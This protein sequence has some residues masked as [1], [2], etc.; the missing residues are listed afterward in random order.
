MLF[1][2]RQLPSHPLVS[3]VTPVLNRVD[4][5]ND[6]LASV[7]AQTYRDIEHIVVDGGSNDGTLDVIRSFEARHDFRWISEPDNGMYDAINKGLSLATGDILA[8]VNSDDLYFP[9]AVEAAVEALRGGEDLV[10]SDVVILE[11]RGGKATGVTLQFYPSFDL[12]HYVHHD[13][14]PQVTC[15]WQRAVMDS[16]GVF[17]PQLRYC[18]DSE[19]W[20]RALA[21]GYRIEH[22][23]EISATVIDHEESFSRRDAEPLARELAMVRA[24]FSPLV[25]RA[26]NGRRR[27]VADTIRWRWRQYALQRQTRRSRPDRWPEF[28]GFLQRAGL[29]IEGSRLL[30]LLAPF[31]LT[32]SRSGWFSAPE[33]ERRLLE[34]L[35]ALAGAPPSSEPR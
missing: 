30:T 6:S 25:G 8:Y 23:D 9:W 17:D 20:A 11:K 7:A 27:K 29:E 24:R 26:T 28:I 16:I 31:R 15:F 32:S 18:G 13:V 19:Y 3:I 2:A 4:T 10:F 21:A 14:M 1:P 35:R 22:F 5:I 12:S 33:F 34:E